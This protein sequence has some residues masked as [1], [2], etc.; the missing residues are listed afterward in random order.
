MK[1]LLPCLLA[2]L[3][4]CACGGE[5]YRVGF[6][7]PHGEGTAL[8]GDHGRLLITHKAVKISAGAGVTG[9]LQVKLVDTQNTLYGPFEITRDEPL[10]R[11]FPPDVTYCIAVAAPNDAAGPVAVELEL[12]NVHLAIE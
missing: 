2:L 12:E 1:K 7:V 5:I 6:A 9:T 10:H 8:G 4:L 3:L 11:H